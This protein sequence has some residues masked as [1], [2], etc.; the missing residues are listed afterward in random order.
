[1]KMYLRKLISVILIFTLLMNT[2]STGFADVLPGKVDIKE[3]QDE[4]L[5]G[6]TGA[7]E[8]TS[9]KAELEKEVEDQISKRYG[10][11][12]LELDK[13]IKTNGLAENIMLSKLLDNKRGYGR[14]YTILDILGGGEG[15]RQEGG[16]SEEEAEAFYEE[17]SKEIN[18]IYG[19]WLEKYKGAAIELADKVIN[20]SGYNSIDAD[21]EHFSSR[22][23]KWEEGSDLVIEILP[24]IK[25]E[26]GEDRYK[27]LLGL[28][29]KNLEIALDVCIKKDAC[30]SAEHLI[31]NQRYMY[32]E[33]EEGKYLL[34]EIFED[35]EV[36]LN[37]L[38]HYGNKT[39]GYSNYVGLIGIAASYFLALKYYNG[40]R[41]IIRD[42]KIAERK[43]SKDEEPMTKPFG[44]LSALMPGTVIYTIS[45]ELDTVVGTYPLYDNRIGSLPSNKGRY[46]LEEGGKEGNIWWD[47]A[48]I[49]SEEGSAESQKILDEEISEIKREGKNFTL[50]EIGILKISALVHRKASGK[51][52]VYSVL[53][54]EIANIRFGD[55]SVIAEEEIDKGLLERYPVIKE[56][57]KAGA[58][59]DGQGKAAKEKATKNMSD[60]RRLCLVID[61]SAMVVGGWQIL[62]LGYNLIKNARNIGVGLYKTMK[63]GRI[64]KSSGKAAQ[65]KYIRNNIQDIRFYKEWKGGI[66]EYEA[67]LLGGNKSIAPKPTVKEIAVKESPAV[68]ETPSEAQQYYMYVEENGH[69][70][71]L[72]IDGK[73]KIKK[74]LDKQESGALNKIRKNNLSARQKRKI[75]TAYQAESEAQSQAKIEKIYNEM[76]HEGLTPKGSK[77]VRYGE[78]NWLQKKGFDLKINADIA[79]DLAADFTNALVG[80]PKRLA[81][82]TVMFG[83]G[84]A[85]AANAFMYENP[86][87]V[88]QA[89]KGTKA[90]KITQPMNLY[91]PNSYFGGA[92][93]HAGGGMGNMP[94]AGRTFRLPKLTLA[95]SQIIRNG[96][97]KKLL[98]TAAGLTA[99]G[100]I[101]NELFNPTGNI[102][103]ISNLL[104]ATSPII[105]TRINYNNLS[106]TETRSMA[107]LE[108]VLLDNGYTEDKIRTFSKQGVIDLVAFFD[109]TKSVKEGTRRKLTK[110]FNP[111]NYVQE[112]YDEPYK[113]IGKIRILFV[114][115][116][117]A[118]RA[119]LQGK[120]FPNVTIDYEDSGN[121]AILTLRD[122]P[123]AYD[124]IITDMVMPAGNGYELAR[125]VHN[126]H[127]HIP[128]ILSS[129]VSGSAEELYQK[130]FDGYI[131]LDTQK[132]DRVINYVSNFLSKWK[133]Y[134]PAEAENSAPVSVDERLNSVVT[135]KTNKGDVNGVIVSLYGK[136]VVITSGTNFK[137]GASEI[138]VQDFYGNSL[139][140]GKVLYAADEFVTDGFPSY[141]NY[142]IITLDETLPNNFPVFTPTDSGSQEM[143][144]VKPGEIYKVKAYKDKSAKWYENTITVSKDQTR[145][146]TQG[147]I[148]LNADGSRIIGIET[149]YFEGKASHIVKINDLK[150]SL[151]EAVKIELQGNDRSK[152]AFSYGK[153]KPLQID[154]N[155]DFT[156]QP[157][158]ITVPVAISN[159]RKQLE[160]NALALNIPQ[161]TI[162]KAN[163]KDLQLL[164]QLYGEMKAGNTLN[165]Y[166][167]DDIAQ[168]SLAEPNILELY[169]KETKVPDFVYLYDEDSAE[170]SVIY[171]K[172]QNTDSKYTNAIYTDDVIIEGQYIPVFKV[173][174]LPV[175]EI[176]AK[177]AK[178][179]ID[180]STILDY[181]ARF[182]NPNIRFEDILRDP[183]FNPYYTADGKVYTHKQILER[184]SKAEEK[185]FVSTASQYRAFGAN[186]RAI[187]RPERVALHKE[188]LSKIFADYK[189]K[190]SDKPVFIVLGGRSGSGKTNALNG[191]VY[192]NKKYVV[193]NAD[194]IK[195]MLPEYA[196]DNTPAVHEESLDVIDEALK[197]AAELH[198]NVVLE[199]TMNDT[200]VLKRRLKMFTDAGYTTE[201]HYIFVPRQEAAKRVLKRF[202]NAKDERYVS[203]QVVLNQKN[204]EKNFNEIKDFVDVWSFSDNNVHEGVTPK[205]IARKGRLSYTEGENTWLGAIQESSLT[206]GTENYTKNP[207]F[208]LR[209]YALPVLGIGLVL[210]AA[211]NSSAMP[212]LTL[213]SFPFFGSIFNS[214]HREDFSNFSPDVQKFLQLRKKFDSKIFSGPVLSTENAVKMKEILGVKFYD[215]WQKYFN[216]DL[217]EYARK[218]PK[219]TEELIKYSNRYESTLKSQINSRFS[220]TNPLYVY[221]MKDIT[222]NFEKDLLATGDIKEAIINMGKPM[223]LYHKKVN[224][225]KAFFEAHRNSKKILWEEVKTP[226][227]YNNINLDENSKPNEFLGSQIKLSDKIAF[228]I[229]G[230]TPIRVVTDFDDSKYGEYW[231]DFLDVQNRPD[232]YKGVNLTYSNLKHLMAGAP[233][234]GG[235]MIHPLGIEKDGF[236]NIEAMFKVLQEDYDIIKPLIMKSKSGQ[237]L[238]ASELETLHNTIAEISYLFTNAKPFYRGSA[239]ANLAIVY[240]LYE[241]AGIK[242]P[243]VRN[244][245]NLDLSAFVTTPQEYQKI[246]KSLFDGN[247]QIGNL[248]PQTT[249]KIKKDG[250]SAQ[251]IFSNWYKDRNFNIV[252][253]DKYHAHKLLP[254]GFN[255]KNSL[256]RGMTLS[257]YEDLEYILK[258]GLEV[259]RT[260]GESAIYFSTNVEDAVDYSLQFAYG[261]LPVIVKVLHDGNF[262]GTG[263]VSIP[264]SISAQDIN[265][266]LVFAYMQG[267]IGW[268]KAALDESGEV[269]L[270]PTDKMEKVEQQNSGF[271]GF[272]LNSN[273]NNFFMAALGVGLGIT[274]LLNGAAGSAL[275]LAAFPFFA[276]FRKPKVIEQNQALKNFIN[277]RKKFNTN[278]FQGVEIPAEDAQKMQ[279]ILGK[280]TYNLWQEY[281]NKKLPQMALDNPDAI[282]DLIKYSNRYEST[283]PSQNFRFDGTNPL[284]VYDMKEITEGFEKDLLNKKSIADAI[285]NMGLKMYTHHKKM[286][287]ISSYL[288]QK[289]TYPSINWKNVETPIQYIDAEKIKN[290]R[291]EAYTIGFGILENVYTQSSTIFDKKLLYSEYWEELINAVQRGKTFK[292]INLSNILLLGRYPNVQAGKIEHPSGVTKKGVNNVRSAFKV[293]QE[294]Y[295]AIEPLIMKSRSGQTLNESELETLHNTIAE[296][297]YIF[298]NVKPFYRGSASAN[299]AIVYGLYH[300]AGIEAPQ[301][302]I[303]R[304]LDLSAF[305]LTP[306]EYK[307]EWKN[308]FNGDFKKST[309]SIKYSPDNISAKDIFTD[310]YKQNNL[311]IAISNVS[312]MLYL[313]ENF[314]EDGAIYRGF[315]VSS[316]QDF[317]DIFYKGL[318]LSKTNIGANFFATRIDNAIDYAAHFNI[319]NFPV[320]VKMISDKASKSREF[321]SFKR[322]IKANEL[323]EVL[324]WA[325]IGDQVGWYKAGLD[326]YGEVVLQPTDAVFTAK[327]SPS[328]FQIGNLLMPAL[329]VGITLTMLLNGSLE[330]ALALAGLPF[331]AS[332]IKPQVRNHNRQVKNFLDFRKNFDPHL[333]TGENLS[334]EE[335]IN[336][337]EILGAKFYEDW[338]KYY[339]Q[340]LSKFASQY[341][342]EM[343]EIIKYSNLYEASL[344]SIMENRFPGTNPLY[345]DIMKETSIAFIQDI[346]AGKDIQ[347]ALLHVGDMRYDYHQKILQIEYFMLQRQDGEGISWDKIKNPIGLSAGFGKLNTNNIEGGAMITP[348][349]IY[350]EYFDKFSKDYKDIK[351]Y[352]GIELTVKTSQNPNS[353]LISY[354]KG[355]ANYTVLFR[356]MQKDLESIKPIIAKHQAGQELSKDDINSLH[357]TIADMSYMLTN[358]VPFIRGTSSMNLTMVYSLYKMAGIE[359]PRVRIG[360]ALDLEAFAETPQEYQANW[361]N[362]FDGKFKVSSADN[363]TVNPSVDGGSFKINNLIM[364]AIAI[365]LGLTA[366]INGTAPTLALATLPFL[367]SFKR[368]SIQKDKIK[369]FLDLRK[370]FDPEIFQGPEL[371]AEDAAKMQEILGTNFYNDWQKY[372]NRE[373]P[374]MVTT[375]TSD[376]EELIKYSNRYENTLPSVINNRFTGT[377]PLYVSMMHKAMQNFENDL[378]KGESFKTAIKYLGFDMYN[379]H[380]KIKQI[381]SYIALKK[382]SNKILDWNKIKNPR[383]YVRENETLR[384]GNQ[385]AYEIGFGILG[386]SE[387]YTPFSKDGYGEYYTELLN[388]YKNHRPRTFKGINLSYYDVEKPGIFADESNFEFITHP[389]SEDSPKGNNIDALFEVL[390]ADYEGIKPLIKKVQS[391]KTLSETEL[392]T[393][394]NTIAEISYLFTNAK[395]FYRGSASANLAIVYGLYEMAGIDVP[396]VK[397]GRALDLSAF[398]TTPEEYKENWTHLFDGD[399]KYPTKPSKDQNKLNLKTDITKLTFMEFWDE[400]A[401]LSDITNK[402]RAYYKRGNKGETHRM[403]IFDI[404]AAEGDFSNEDSPVILEYPKVLST[405]L[406]DLPAEIAQK[407]KEKYNSSPYTE[408]II[409]TAVNTSGYV[410]YKDDEE[411]LVALKGKPITNK[412][413]ERFVEIIKH[414]H[415][416]GFYHTD[417]VYNTFFRRNAK[418]KLVVTI[419]DFD[420]WGR[421]EVDESDLE[422]IREK[423]EFI[424]AKEKPEE[425][426]VSGNKVVSAQILFTQEYKD[427][428]IYVSWS[429][430]KEVGNSLPKGFVEDGAIYRGMALSK[431]KD[432]EQIFKAGL[433]VNKTFFKDGVYFS[434]DIEDALEYATH[435]AAF[436][437]LPVIVKTHLENPKEDRYISFP[438]GVDAKH[439]DEVLVWAE[440]NGKLDWYP[441]ILD[442][443]KQ[444]VLV[445]NADK[446]KLNSHTINIGLRNSNLKNLIM[447]AIGISLGLTALINGVAGPALVLASIPFFAS[448]NKPKLMQKKKVSDFIELR[449]GF[450]SGIF[451]GPELS[452]EDAQNLKDILGEDFFNVWQKYYNQNF[453]QF[454][455]GNPSDVHNIIAA[456]NRYETTL[457]S[458]IYYRFKGTNP[459]FLNKM[460][461]LSNLLKQNLLKDVPIKRA[462]VELG[463]QMFE[464]HKDIF[465]LQLFL[466]H[467]KTN[468]PINWEYIK[469]PPIYPENFEEDENF[470]LAEDIGYGKLNDYFGAGLKIDRGMYGEYLLEAVYAYNHP[471]SYKGVRLPFVDRIDKS[472]FY[473]LYPNGTN[474]GGNNN[475]IAFV[476]MQSDF[477]Q[478]K[479]LILKAQAGT[480]LTELELK[481]LHEN[482]ADIS[483]IF[484]N[485]VPFY[486]GTSAANLALVYTL[487]DMAGIKA[488]QV[489]IG[490]QLD[491]TA[492]ITT[493]DDYKKQWL[494]YLFDGDFIQ[495]GGKPLD[496]KQE[497]KKA[498]IFTYKGATEGQND[499]VWQLKDAYGNT[500]AYFEYVTP[501]DVKKIK[502]LDKI[503]KRRKLAEKFNLI[504]FEYPKLLSTRS[505]SLP[506]EVIASIENDVKDDMGFVTARGNELTETVILSPI[507]SSGFSLKGMDIDNHTFRNGMLLGNFKSLKAEGLAA[508]RNSPITTE[509]WEQL[510]GLFQSLDNFYLG[511]LDKVFLSRDPSGK[512]VVGILDLGYGEEPSNKYILSDIRFKLEALGLK[513]DRAVGESRGVK[514]DSHFYHPKAFSVKNLIMPA[515]GIGIGLTALINGVAGPAMVLAALPF[516]ASFN[517]IGIPLNKQEQDFLDLRKRFDSKIFQG[518]ELYAEEASNMKEILGTDFFDLWQK[519][520]NQELPKII[521]Q[522]TSETDEFIKLSNR[523]ENTLRSIISHRFNGTNP[524]FVY[525]MKDLS[526]TFIEDLLSGK[527]MEQ[528]VTKMG[529]KMFTYHKKINQIAAFWDYKKSKRNLLNW[530]NIKSPKYYG[531]L[532]STH[533]SDIGFGVFKRPGH[534]YGV[535]IN[536]ISYSEYL[537]RSMQEYA[538]PKDNK[539][540][541][542]NLTYFYKIV[543]RDDEVLLFYPDVNDKSGVKNNE[544][545]FAAMQDDWENIKPIIEKHQSGKK[546]TAR[547]IKLLH[548]NI[549]DISY[550][551]TNAVPFY[552]GSASANLAIVYG[553]YDAAGVDAPKIKFGRA[554]D[555][556][557]FITSPEQY[558][559]NWLN[560][561]DGDF[562]VATIQ[563]SSVSEQKE[564]PAQILF[565]GNYETDLSISNENSKELMKYLPSDF[566]ED[567]TIYRGMRFYSD[568]YEDLE[569]VLKVG[570]LTNKTQGVE[571]IFFSPL[572]EMAIDYAKRVK[573]GQIPVL[574]KMPYKQPNSR[575]EEFNSMID[576]RGIRT[577]P[578]SNEVFFSED[579]EA[580]KLTGTLVWAELDGKK[581]WWRAQLNNKGEVV[582]Q[583]TDNMQ[584]ITAPKVK[585]PSNSTPKSYN[586]LIPAIIGG[587]GLT[588]LLS[589]NI[590]PTLALAS[591]PLL[592]STRPIINQNSA[593]PAKGLFTKEY[594]ESYMFM[595]DAEPTTDYLP[596]DFEEDDVLY[597]GMTL[598]VNGYEDLQG[599]LLNGLSGYK[600]NFGEIYF[601]SDIET[602]IDYSTQYN[603]GH[604]PILIKSNADADI[605]VRKHIFTFRDVAPENITDVLVWAN[606]GGKIGWWRAQLDDNDEVVLIPTDNMKIIE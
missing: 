359:A 345:A 540:K 105:S 227:E 169:K 580:D 343:D 198:V 255:E 58:V 287:Q 541:G 336:M 469:N 144:F 493:P 141:Q 7:I 309:S 18:E 361:T 262:K 470:D 307:K 440:I 396:Q 566:L 106:L 90:I 457:P 94:K 53:A 164:V 584:A 325:S 504:S 427:K 558:K 505:S 524:L 83:T 134:N 221:T 17:Y 398:V 36:I 237:T 11:L 1:M 179:D 200:R 455:K 192:D 284:Y 473:M 2:F 371:S 567:N 431:H 433:P 282:E 110:D 240:G 216:E 115:D 67:G 33:G 177:V 312:K 68:K 22:M 71:K 501:N 203:P 390:Q 245:R 475:D 453:A 24:F 482:I 292:G 162:S 9:K 477:D 305:S 160:Q 13:R 559:A 54:Q 601:T 299:L 368:V 166:H 326:D 44:G 446:N 379:Y 418:G 5:E 272:T 47:L 187:Y 435:S 93:V 137:D 215:D 537:D 319:G 96:T 409:M 65:I 308:L 259:S 337:K 45:E 372:Y 547:D 599:I 66:R 417:L 138:S 257:S 339:N 596:S 571:T 512:L 143:Y 460:S 315:V 381:S 265:E 362:L 502:Q 285:T 48:D 401:Q 350:H 391:G 426:L 496:L 84:E 597:R 498:D 375:H 444:P 509:E 188:I 123:D 364:P 535:S 184:I 161:A 26:I 103:D 107:E 516:F 109:A 603:Y 577:A 333:F 247:F 438:E 171:L 602:A 586:F 196:G 20:D 296:I 260:R 506:K 386:S 465:R 295:S 8:P 589:G 74:T 479:P 365:G 263:Y 311:P 548:E 310:S 467:K 252:M 163:D 181:V 330:P 168:K 318:M 595:D 354:P 154:R 224:Q 569:T 542:V 587:L 86:V 492:F 214:E 573:E 461:Q 159:A 323:A 367:A 588:M 327:K 243:Q 404:I 407:I 116:N 488:P 531:S 178:G 273:F 508:L 270:T 411:A 551:F 445:L 140:K 592:A 332:F 500:D 157:M 201:A 35:G 491:L 600:T 388:S 316:Y 238:T 416:N 117:P 552:R 70:Y 61:I 195:T 30:A 191:V 349:S 348:S 293:L 314:E 562:E 515:I 546:L 456:S 40:I 369:S 190:V 102:L 581:G 185:S 513:F 389:I 527:D 27:K 25:D 402:V 100:L 112:T 281:Y 526:D 415:T 14:V 286:A 424:G 472:G 313:P 174:N 464:Y 99:I 149:G 156:K 563:Q 95:P 447:P 570:L 128:V 131:V 480:K 125:Y 85:P 92:S 81:L 522:H 352:K 151:P 34:N 360:K 251:L 298:A 377:N 519:Y 87:Q 441:V 101:A 258:R 400:L 211:I 378:L 356:E 406:T 121:A 437:H 209:R 606:L 380:K 222:D 564:I 148:I 133:Y 139:G 421:N 303:G 88:V 561:F 55:L 277:L 46:M 536:P 347:E 557:A 499:Y 507:S 306:Q 523:Y 212:F 443:K 82:T 436:G 16:L 358:A 129:T 3:M 114:N 202:L 521:A 344:P 353:V 89:V 219:D 248:A 291:H 320:L 72:S 210:T 324:V 518:P 373:L 276:S 104:L 256:F 403:E 450:D 598:G 199:A 41:R 98:R 578:P 575:R 244:R 250:I 189:G 207:S 442:E 370:G 229:F 269:I 56:G 357:K 267:E 514:S 231:T 57:L 476:A 275:T 574:V 328:K 21:V 471:E 193:I 76:I 346:S 490:R 15:K 459:L 342:E 236:N 153:D 63:A 395:P 19:I 49:L 43:L 232:T 605:N 147:G 118:A 474:K 42:A 261:N 32:L 392:K 579:I 288:N 572:A 448:F 279:E 399:F 604:L 425:K 208:N 335:A 289:Y 29:R 60:L 550:L 428:D 124:I 28:S 242:A 233:S 366:L 130:Y 412:E 268:W 59:V 590:A 300:M 556:E 430:L 145:L 170:F 449:K 122:N 594:I 503:V 51:D 481:T 80:N 271:V 434:Q 532:N 135:V 560:L 497:I 340:D 408:D 225:I 6:V 111:S 302:K 565:S 119:T 555:L 182:D 10:E 439:I 50:G 429:E 525:H 549:A 62:K 226:F 64:G 382:Q 374:Q 338:Q 39:E 75:R 167:N 23:M 239:S 534:N 483:Y 142:A 394:H 423:L 183:I 230:D 146:G 331:F 120:N 266:V 136:K 172:G 126:K 317:T 538:H 591:L 12:K 376:I 576:N 91:D 280:R 468:T 452:T 77:G 462:L 52:K 278:F 543:E 283:L 132:E 486:R 173:N 413:W 290:G 510:V 466:E 79:S 304:A 583:P 246:W 253:R 194:D 322:D 301:V 321:I 152:I 175:G 329:G 451:Q 432:L 529:D 113:D 387:S 544:S 31:V 494:M 593:I 487:Y 97:G 585:S 410:L 294:D 582:L 393:L 241:M 568:S 533:N 186:E 397:I 217:V 297:S 363:K 108:Q 213:A 158:K 206:L 274:F 422:K 383:V 155:F 254:S 528:A 38:K 545:L 530:L 478:I 351:K 223:F 204:G 234:Y 334:A 176:S 539:Y 127:L 517:K 165:V 220:G 235:T 485:A 4:I 37:G 405:K 264:N 495:T 228:G 355:G 197:M 463:N 205:L 385:D 454:A 520:Y 484:T 249:A 414:F 554:L 180:N 218:N 489:R 69:T 553:L 384:N 511:N 419:I 420:N 341:P 78:L 150:Y 458:L 73:G